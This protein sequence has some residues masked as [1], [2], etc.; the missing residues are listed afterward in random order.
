MSRRDV[1]SLQSGETTGGTQE[2]NMDTVDIERVRRHWSRLTPEISALFAQL[3]D[4]PELPGMED[5]AVAALTEFLR[6][7][8]FEV[9]SPVGDVPTAFIARKGSGSG[10]SVAILAEY[11]ALPSLDNLAVARRTGTGRRPGHACG[12]NHIGPANSAAAVAAAIAAAESGLPGEIVVVGCPGEEIGWGKPALQQA[13]LFD[14]FDA[15]LTSHGDYQNASL[16]RPCHAIVSGE[17]VFRGDSAHAGMGAS[18]NALKTA[19]E[20]MA[21][22]LALAPERFP[23]TNEKHVFRSAGIMP[24]VMPDEVRLWTSLRHRD[25]DAVMRAYEGLKSIFKEVAGKAGVDL[26]EKFVSASRGYLPN[27]VLGRLLDECLRTVG[28]PR[29][30][31]QDIAFMQQLAAAATPG[32]PFE[33]HREIA[34]FNDGID[35]YAQDDGDASWI[36]PLGRVN[37]AYPKGVPIHHWA[38]TALSGHPASS[39]GAMMA[40]EA[41]ALAAFMLLANPAHLERAK[42]E[43]RERVGDQKIKV[44]PPGIAGIMRADPVAFWEARW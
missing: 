13:G 10:P 42:A 8:G 35:Y 12:H 39:P 30:S 41:L 19:E 24:G 38:W 33:L 31:E 26:E 11:D 22:F 4:C 44:V 3:W 25:F 7:R 37:W 23:N 6:R 36:V 20:A 5:K 14:R 9:K 29:W 40:S 2:M 21:T 15:L 43:L 1:T 16:S 18:R 27:D 17:F 28:P 32:K 34:Y